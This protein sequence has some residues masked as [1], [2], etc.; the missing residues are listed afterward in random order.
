MTVDGCVGSKLKFVGR[1]ATPR[2]ACLG[3]ARLGPLFHRLLDQHVY[4]VHS[5]APG[6]MIS[7]SAVDGSFNVTIQV[8]VVKNIILC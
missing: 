2:P 8:L 5:G 6:Q 1:P 3:S 4:E 7:V